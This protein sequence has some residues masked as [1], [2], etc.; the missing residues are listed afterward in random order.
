[1]LLPEYVTLCC[2]AQ[3]PILFDPS[4]ILSSFFPVKRPSFLLVLNFWKPPLCTV[5]R[6]ALSAEELLPIA[7]RDEYTD[8]GQI[9]GK[10]LSLSLPLLLSVCLRD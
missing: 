9:P 8:H 6:C 4:F 10:S 7:L 2:T 3:E 5:R 1:M